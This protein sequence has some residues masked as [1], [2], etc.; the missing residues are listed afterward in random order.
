MCQLDHRVAFKPIILSLVFYIYTN[1]KVVYS[2][3][4]QYTI[5]EFCAFFLLDLVPRPPLYYLLSAIVFTI[6]T[7]PKGDYISL[8]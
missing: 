7:P 2:Q 6:A 1:Q 4:M 3:V 8:S 5:Q